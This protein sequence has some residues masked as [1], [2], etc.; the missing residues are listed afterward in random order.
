MSELETTPPNLPAPVD[1]P[2]MDATKADL[3]RLKNLGYWMAVAAEGKDLK[4]KGAANAVR[5]AYAESLGLPLH[6]ASEIHIING[7]LAL[8][9]QMKRAQAFV[10]GYEVFPT[11]ETDDSCTVEIRERATGKL[12]GQPVTFT[13]ADA[14]RMGLMDKP[15]KAW[16]QSP[17]EM[18][19]ARAS[20]KAIRRHIPHVSLGVMTIEEAEDYPHISH[21]VE[22]LPFEDAD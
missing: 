1:S 19:F 12:V 15:G 3:E 13:L 11:E 18:L 21:E 22:V 5:M 16:H 14:K 9:A 20:S 17:S 2:A 6:A 7:Q 4:A 10:H 8:S